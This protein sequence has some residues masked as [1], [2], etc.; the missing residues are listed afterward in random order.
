M[1]RSY[2]LLLLLALVYLLPAQTQPLT[3]TSPNGGEVWATGSTYDITWTHTNLTGNVNLM[4]VGGNA[5]PAHM[6]IAEDIPVDAGIYGWTI[7]A[8]VIPGTYYRVRITHPTDNNHLIS[9]VSDAP[10]TITGDTPPPPPPPPPPVGALELTAPNG[11]EIWE[12]GLTY[13]ITWTSEDLTGNVTLALIGGRQHGPG[14]FLIAED[15]PVT[16]GSFTWTVPATVRPSDR[17]RVHI[18]MGVCPDVIASDLSDAPFSIIGDPLPPDPSVITVTAPNGGEIWEKGSTYTI[19]W[20]DLE[21]IDTVKIFLIRGGNQHQHRFLINAE[22]PNTG[23]YEWLIPPAVQPGESYKIQVVR[24]EAGMDVS[25]GFFTILE[26]QVN[27]KASP[28][29]T[30]KGTT[31]SFELKAPASATVRIYNARG[32]AIRT[33][34]QDQMLSGTQSINWDGNDQQGRKVSNGVYFARISAPAL[35][36]SQKIIV[37]K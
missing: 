9:D 23:S 20:T 17:Y 21:Y 8:T 18:Y 27:V 28:N 4:L 33:L 16:D 24:P 31:I 22:A 6:L 29:P 11:G 35:N 34:V 25:D 1:K 15:I 10:F 12:A 2:L 26:P 19:T 7:P 32:Q 30:V 37:I 3:L 14:M 5:H 13:A 36:A